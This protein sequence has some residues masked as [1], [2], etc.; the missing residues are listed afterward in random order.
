MPSPANPGNAFVN[1]V[2]TYPHIAA[3]MVARFTTR[4]DRMAGL[5]GARVAAGIRAVLRTGYLPRGRQFEGAGGRQLVRIAWLM[6]VRESV[7]NPANLAHVPM[8]LD[9]LAGRNQSGAYHMSMGEAM[10]GHEGDRSR[11][12]GGGAYPMSM[13]G[14]QQAA[15]D[16]EH[17]VES[18]GANELKRR[19][20]EL[21]RR[22]LRTRGYNEIYAD[23]RAAVKRLI[24]DLVAR[25]YRR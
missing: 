18:P 15:R 23:D 17:G 20:A 3:S 12:G 16:I 5:G 2:R 19:E 13:R 14:A 9:L 8:T 4:R 25:S 6:T 22:W 1:W 7:R 21:I 11:P 24:S 10:A